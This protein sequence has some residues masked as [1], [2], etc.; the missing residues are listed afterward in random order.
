MITHWNRIQLSWW[1]HQKK[2]KNWMIL[3]IALL[4][5]V[6]TN[7]IDPKKSPQLHRTAS[8]ATESVVWFCD[9]IRLVWTQSIC[10]SD[11]GVIKYCADFCECIPNW[12]L[13]SFNLEHNLH[14]TFRPPLYRECELDPT[15]QLNSISILCGKV[16]SYVHTHTQLAAWNIL[17]CDCLDTRKYLAIY[18]EFLEGVRSISNSLPL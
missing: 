6:Q 18:I 17:T 10:I 3:L 12:I 13:I 5:I 15:T 16:L 2:K 7:E 4:A 9:V 1:S 8:N 14:V 11:C